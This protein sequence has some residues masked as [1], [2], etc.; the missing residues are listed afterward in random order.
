M[1]IPVPAGATKVLAFRI[2]GSTRNR[3][4]ARLVKAGWNPERNRGESQDLIMEMIESRS[5]EEFHF[6]RH[7]SLSQDLQHLRAEHDALALSVVAQGEAAI[8]LV[9]AE[10][11]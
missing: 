7:I 10:F 6:H 3:V 1:A 4:E 9:A 8:W 2:A 11:E 5:N